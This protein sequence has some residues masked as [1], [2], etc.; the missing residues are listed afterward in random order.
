MDLI[1][2]LEA[3]GVLEANKSLV[4]MVLVGLGFAAGVAL[5][6]YRHRP[7]GQLLCALSLGL[8]LA[9]ALPLG[10]AHRDAQQDK[11]A[12]VTTYVEKQKPTL[13]VQGDVAISAYSRRATMDAVDD[14][15]DAFDV[16]LT[17][18]GGGGRADRDDE[19]LVQVQV[20]PADRRER[21]RSST[22]TRSVTPTP[23]PTATPARSAYDL[24]AEN[25]A[26]LDLADKQRLVEGLKKDIAEAG[27]RP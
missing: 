18:A 23:S 21:D 1:T 19:E 24:V 20:E 16:T 13:T 22:P 2:T 26:G 15:G 6:D 9:G 14:H 17:W 3:G 27:G 10:Q 8:A 5:S 12:A 25:A 11:V 4:L 7:D